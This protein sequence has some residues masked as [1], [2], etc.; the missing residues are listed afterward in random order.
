MNLFLFA[1]SLL[2]ILLPSQSLSNPPSEP[3]EQTILRIQEE[4]ARIDR[5]TSLRIESGWQ[6]FSQAAYQFTVHH[7]DVEIVKL[8]QILFTKTEAFHETVYFPNRPSPLFIYR[9]T[10]VQY[11]DQ[12]RWISEEENYYSEGELLPPL[13]RGIRILPS[14]H[15]R[16]DT[17]SWVPSAIQVED[18]YKENRRFINQVLEEILSISFVPARLYTGRYVYAYD[19]ESFGECH[20]DRTYQ[21][22]DKTLRDTY[23]SLE[24]KS[25]EGAI[26]TFVATMD[27][28]EDMMGEMT[29]TLTVVELVS[30][31]KQTDCE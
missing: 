29:E 19:T 11:N 9:K 7:N 4:V 14:S 3:N 2:T 17:V 28:Q 6:H 13:T 31:R 5:D 15:S 1:F 22:E 8:T 18:A 26:A 25:F 23:A 30:M 12:S 10:A 24:I 27:L 20:T 16:I 21:I